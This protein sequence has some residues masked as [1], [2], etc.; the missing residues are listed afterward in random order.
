MSARRS[1]RAAREGQGDA[2]DP[3]LGAGAMRRRKSVGGGG[4]RNPRSLANLKRGDNAAPPGNLRRETHGAYRRVLDAADL[5]SA[6]RRV[7]EALAADAPVR[8]A[9]GELPAADAVMVRLLADAL[10]RLDGIRDY[11]R[12]RGLEDEHG[13]VRESVLDLERRLRIEVDQRADSLGM[14]A[15]SRARLG[16]D[17]ARAAATLE[18]EL[19]AGRA[20]WERRLRVVDGREVPDDAA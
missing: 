5:E 2:G 10:V 1:A 4:A 8:D 9:N 12:R 13:R 7:F 11:L 19:A 15:T 17:L 3:D 20:A 18:D 16:L 6:E 14:S